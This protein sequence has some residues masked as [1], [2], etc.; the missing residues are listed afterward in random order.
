ME[1]T[2]IYLVLLVVTDGKRV[3]ASLT[4]AG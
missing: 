1:C 4:W 3:F 2:S